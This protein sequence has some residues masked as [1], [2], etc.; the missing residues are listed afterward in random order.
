MK[1]RLEAAGSSDSV[2]FRASGESIPIERGGR[3]RSDF[4]GNARGGTGPR[5]FGNFRGGF[6]DGS[7]G[8]F[9]GSFR[10]GPRGGFGRGG[11]GGAF[12]PCWI[13]GSSAHRRR[14]CPHKLENS[15][16]LVIQRKLACLKCRRLG[17]K[18]ADCTMSTADALGSGATGALC[19]NCGVAGHS[20]FTCPSAK[21]GNGM[22][23]ASC[24]LCGKTGHLA[25]SCE[26]NTLGVYP[27][28]G[29]CKVCGSI[30]H[31]AKD[32]DAAAESGAVAADGGSTS[33]PAALP[34]LSAPTAVG[35]GDDL[36]GSF[37]ITNDDGGSVALESDEG[38][39]RKHSARVVSKRGSHASRK[40]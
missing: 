20:C 19:F 15:E 27:R 18:A 21:V 37:A 12:E 2:V 31:L 29:S 16:G 32:C 36:D 10:G 23:Y 38:K 17:H 30:R 9:G 24:F 8:G 33:Y 4:G 25:K 7:R 22:T 11:N 35:T 6:R 26:K 14:D 28:G 40:S 5:G 3:G 39:L 34:E 13:C 1:R